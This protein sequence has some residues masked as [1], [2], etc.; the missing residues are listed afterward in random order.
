MINIFDKYIDV[1]F[2]KLGEVIFIDEVFINKMNKYKYVCVILDFN[3]FKIID[4]IVMWYKNYLIEYFLRIFRVERFGVKVVVIDMWL[5]YY[6]VVKFC[7]LNVFIV[8]DLFYII[9]NFNEVIK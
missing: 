4:I 6:D 8:I 7:F 9:K 3:I 2:R 5:I 1:Y